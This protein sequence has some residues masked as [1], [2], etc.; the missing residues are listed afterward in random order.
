MR[1]FRLPRAVDSSSSDSDNA[2]SKATWKA[3]PEDSKPTHQQVQ[4]SCSI[5][6]DNTCRLTLFSAFPPLL[7]SVQ[8]FFCSRTHSQLSQFVS[9]LQRTTFADT[10]A[11]V[12][13]ASRKVSSVPIHCVASSNVCHRQHMQQLEV[14]AHSN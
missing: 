10:I 12:S 11:S 8:V 2:G 3:T 13:L 4:R 14:H 9:E 6:V 7:V 1:L 5:N